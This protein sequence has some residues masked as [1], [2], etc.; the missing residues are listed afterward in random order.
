M[1]L[2]ATVAMIIGPG[3]EHLEEMISF[4]LCINR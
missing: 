1:V 2:M 3:L 4:E